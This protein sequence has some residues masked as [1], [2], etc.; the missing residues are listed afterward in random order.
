LPTSADT[1]YLFFRK[2]R[3]GCSKLCGQL[4]A[5]VMDWYPPSPQ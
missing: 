4:K 2:D 1:L 5:M 3:D